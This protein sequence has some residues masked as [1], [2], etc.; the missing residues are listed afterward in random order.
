MPKLCERQR[1]ATGLRADGNADASGAMSLALSPDGSTLLALTSGFNAQYSYPDGRAIRFP[2]PNSI[3]GAISKVTTEVTQWI[4]IYNVGAGGTLQLS[5]RISRDQSE[6]IDH[7]G[8][9][10]LDRTRRDEN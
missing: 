9:A 2:V 1:F 5:Q 7:R 3:T 8:A 6:K 4:F 10:K